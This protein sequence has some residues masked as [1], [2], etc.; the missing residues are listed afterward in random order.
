VYVMCLREGDAFSFEGA[1]MKKDLLA[2]IL[3][4]AF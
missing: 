4:K 2:E 1:K 3:K